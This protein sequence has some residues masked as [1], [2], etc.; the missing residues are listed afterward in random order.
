VTASGAWKWAKKA[1]A[2][3][4]TLPA[5]GM[6]WACAEIMHMTGASAPD[7]A[8]GTL[9]V[10]GFAG[11]RV[12]HL[13]NDRQKARKHARHVTAGITTVGSWL[14][15]ATAAG[16]LGMPGH[17]LTW[18]WAAGSLTGYWWL[19]RHEVVV[20]ARDWRN[21]K[22]DWLA[23]CHRWG[24]RG[25]HLLHHEQTRLGELMIADVTGTGKRASQI[26]HGDLAERIAEE[27]GL[28]VSRVQVKTHRIAGRVEISI[29]ERNPWAHPIT[30]P[31]LCEEPEIDLS[32]PCTVRQPLIVGQDPETGR[33]LTLA[34][35]DE[36]GGKRVMVT[37]I[38]RG[39][40][41]VLLN[42]VRER[43]TAAPDGLLININ[44][45]KALE[46][47]E[48]APACHL[49]AITKGQA[50]RALKIL[51]LLCAIIEWRSQQPRDDAVFQPSPS[52]PLLVAI[53]DEIDTLAAIP[54]ARPL[55]KYV[56]S[57][58]GSEGVAA[59]SAGQ[60]G[61]AEW[62]G[63][64]DVRSQADVFAISQVS[65]R[66][67]MMHAAGDLG[68]M[69]PDMA[70]YGEGHKGVWFL[71]ELG[72]AQ[73][74]GRTFKL[75][76]P[77]DLRELAAERAALQPDLPAALRAFLG[78]SYEQLLST[79]VFAQWA[80]QQG[81]APV[82][83]HPRPDSPAPM[84][85][86]PVAVLSEEDQL[87]ELDSEAEDALDDDLRRKWRATGRK[88]EAAKDALAETMAMPM[89]EVPR[90]VQH[91]R[92]D[93]EWLALGA[94]TPVTAE[95]REALTVLLKG[96]TTIPEVANA[97]GVSKWSARCMIEH[98]RSEGLV[99][100]EGDRRTS[101]WFLVPRDADA[102]DVS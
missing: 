53:I 1:P 94:R 41:T 92:A 101:R 9:A 95:Q 57:K 38:T 61:L 6:T 97:L 54:A 36:D 16:P 87:A 28:P 23:S 59:V 50:G 37:A 35:W 19:R 81:P 46:D 64:G 65:R 22:T 85:T 88:L 13:G 51:R 78:D 39:G 73:Q 68:M 4:L 43:V 20:A 71:A 47:K 31:V 74:I 3:R 80:R 75:K 55:L 67:E 63:G 11:L 102:G 76:E 17:A 32:G 29:R 42:C 27:R 69:M 99:R 58:G 8:L 79:D 84:Q 26:A 7:V 82:I 14:A 2:E 25:S 34:L 33:P 40:K 44:L 15:V 45:S 89:P 70:S 66:G 21:A 62:V 90:E 48:W 5:C 18:T 52:D 77:G 30:H 98:L 49:T 91:A 72:G 24:L 100:K 96:G 93:A 56:Y 60:R 10:A 86:S 12:S 83:A